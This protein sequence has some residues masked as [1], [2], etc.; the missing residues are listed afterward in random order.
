MPVN[1]RHVSQI[2]RFDFIVHVLSPFGVAFTPVKN[3]MKASQFILII[4]VCQMISFSLTGHRGRD[5]CLSAA[6]PALFLCRNRLRHG[7]PFVLGLDTV[8]LLF[9]ERFNGGYIEGVLLIGKAD[10]STGSIRSASSM[11]SIS[12]FFRVMSR[13]R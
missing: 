13:R 11:I 1:G 7:E 6:R 12:I 3:H 4:P 8:Q 2:Q 5:G 10:R 9:D